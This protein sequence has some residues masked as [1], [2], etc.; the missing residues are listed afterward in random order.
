MGGMNPVRGVITLLQGMQ[1]RV[2]KEGIKKQKEF[3]AFMCYCGKALSKQKGVLDQEMIDLDGLTT[4]VNKD[5]ATKLGLEGQMKGQNGDKKS[6]IDAIKEASNLRQKSAM[7]YAKESVR[8]KNNIGAL[9]RAISAVK[10]GIFV[11]FLQNSRNMAEM[12][13]IANDQDVWQL[14]DDEDDSPHDTFVAFL[15]G[16][17][18]SPK[19]LEVIGM[20]Q[21][22]LQELQTEL[23]TV[24]DK[25]A[26]SRKTFKEL[27]GAKQREV[28]ILDSALGQ[29]AVKRGNL[30][31]DIL[32]EQELFAQLQEAYE[33]NYAILREI[34]F[35]CGM[36]K[37]HHREEMKKI[38]NSQVAIY[39]AIGV[40]SDD[41]SLE[42]FKKVYR[43][44]TGGGPY[45]TDDGQ[46]FEVN[47]LQT[48]R[49]QA[50]ALDGIRQKALDTI[51]QEASK[52][53]ADLG[54][55]FIA[56]ALHGKRKGFEMIINKVG[57][58]IRSLGKEQQKDDWKQEDCAKEKKEMDDKMDDLQ[59]K[60]SLSDQNLEDKDIEIKKFTKGR[61]ALAEWVQ[62]LVDRIKEEE[63]WYA[64]DHEMYLEETAEK[65]QARRILDVAANKLN[66]FYAPK[67]WTPA[68]DTISLLQVHSDQNESDSNAADPEEVQKPESARKEESDIPST[69]MKDGERQYFEFKKYNVQRSMH[70]DVIQKITDLQL[71][72]DR[73]LIEALA[74][75]RYERRMTNKIV[76]QWS[77]LLKRK[78]WELDREQGYL[79]KANQENLELKEDRELLD[80]EI[81]NHEKDIAAH[82]AECD[83]TLKYHE[84]RR[85]ARKGEIESLENALTVLKGSDP[86]MFGIKVDVSLAQA[87]KQKEPKAF[88]EPH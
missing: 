44:S 59:D 21:Q 69:E 34:Q 47:F 31:N 83:W 16:G 53:K 9:N 45:K 1:K 36:A 10:K 29:E 13:S 80:K 54:T 71:E 41:D 2:E 75:D 42:L 6:D 78:R 88:L 25:E 58:L 7:E 46:R 14:M 48:R 85:V 51:R 26:L 15:Q 33:S 84:L 43:R 74:R 19:S 8:L 12:Q 22:L 4:D 17:E 20:L 57:K 37:T 18:G 65:V 3:D 28:K 60:K 5:K 38:K 86:E 49:T 67:V 64:E 82:K 30:M 35:E 52:R 70:A 81:A 62:N 63:D 76:G 24:Q 11:D 73:D 66:K 56:L 87:K 72:I 32:A 27:M 68:H 77:D 40:L 55:N 50:K 23:Q 79:D 61:D 39:Q